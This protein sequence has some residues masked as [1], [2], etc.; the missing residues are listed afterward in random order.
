MIYEQNENINEI[1]IR[2]K[3]DEILEFKGT[4]IGHQRI[5]PAYQRRQKK[6]LANLIINNMI[7]SNKYKKN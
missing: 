7:L 4:V 5:A 1:Q 3:N 2:K 6:E